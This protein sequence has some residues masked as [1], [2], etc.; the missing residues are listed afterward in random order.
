MRE[1]E[2]TAMIK[3]SESEDKAHVTFTTAIPAVVV[4][5]HSEHYYIKILK[6][7]IYTELLI[8]RTCNG[9]RS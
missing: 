3:A 6:L 9:K 5:K 8:I 7:C 1:R 2:R 4:I